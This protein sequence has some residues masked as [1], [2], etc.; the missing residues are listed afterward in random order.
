MKLLKLPKMISDKECQELVAWIDNLEIGE[1]KELR[2]LKE[3]CAKLRML[4]LLTDPAVSNEQMNDLTL[5][6]WQAFVKEF[7]DEAQH[8]NSCHEWGK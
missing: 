8:A 5:K 2:A 3:K 4:L 1:V 6:Q 7:P